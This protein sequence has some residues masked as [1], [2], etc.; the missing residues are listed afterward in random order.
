MT[1][2][3]F[4]ARV[5]LQ[6]N[7]FTILIHS[8]ILLIMIV[9]VQWTP[10]YP[11]FGEVELWEAVPTTTQKTKAPPKAKSEIKNTEK[12][13]SSEETQKIKDDQA[14]IN[15][16]QRKAEELA[17]KKKQEE[18][19][20]VQQELLKEEQIKK[21]Q[22]QL[23]REEKIEKLQQELLEQELELADEEIISDDEKK[24]EKIAIEAERELEAG[25][26]K[27]EIDKYKALI[28]QKIQQ[29]VNNNLCGLDYLS[30]AFE[31]TLLPSGELLSDPILKN[32]SQ[33]ISCDEAV[34]RAIFQ[35]E[36]LPV[37]TDPKLFAKL[38]KLKL[39]FYP[40]GQPE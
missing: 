7:L 11:Y 4:E 36:P 18:I 31:I 32:S 17:K 23:L 30:L 38:K 34:E 28:Q 39:K 21:L 15:L 13:L 20:K 19:R 40:N 10:Q 14:E 25:K 5:D 3:D 22:E 29:N 1:M 33:N 12:K 27:G 6:S 2:K 35:S 9:T 24:T 16:K 37:P 26:N 8:I